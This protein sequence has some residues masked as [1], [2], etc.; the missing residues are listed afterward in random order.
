MTSLQLLQETQ[1]LQ[2][3][4]MLCA[5]LYCTAMF[6]LQIRELGHPAHAYT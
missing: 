2:L 4:L 5:A 1:G 6:V 3:D